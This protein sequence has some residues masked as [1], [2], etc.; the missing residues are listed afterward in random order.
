[1]GHAKTR[2]Q[3]LSIV[4]RGGRVVF[5]G[6]HG[7]EVN[8]HGNS[9]VRSEFEIV[10]SFAYS[11]DDFRRAVDLAEEGFIDMNG[12]WL[13]VRPLSAGQDAFAEQAKGPAT[14]SK[15]LLKP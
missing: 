5:V 3:G 12:G 6:L 10:G 7:D 2:T 1:V 14:F 8:L 13:D 15:I 4:R 9:I 11:D